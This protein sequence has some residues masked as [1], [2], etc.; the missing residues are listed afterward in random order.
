MI[1]II[2]KNA[3]VATFPEGFFADKETIGLNGAALRFNAH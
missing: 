1:W 2:G 3:S